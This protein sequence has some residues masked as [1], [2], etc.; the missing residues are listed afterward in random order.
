MGL[1]ILLINPNRY[2]SP[3]VIPIGLEYLTTSLKK[4]GYNV[5]ILDLCFTKLP[6]KILAE[7]LEKEKYDLIGITI[8]NIDSAIFFN[9]IFFLTEIKKLI[10]YI[11]KYNIPIILGGSGFSA[12]PYEILDYLQADYGIIGPGEVIFPK[13][14]EIWQ[15]KK[16]TQKIYNGWKAGIDKKLIHLRGNLIN[17]QYYLKD[18]G[19]IGFETHVGCSNQ[20]PYCIEANTKVYFKEIKAIIEELKYLIR[21]GY[22]HFHTCDTEFNTD[23][24]FSLDFCKA[25]IKE[26]LEFKWALYMKPNPYSE[27]LFKL[28]H[29][30]NAYLI[31]LSVDSYEQIQTLNNYNYNDLKK[32]IE[33]SKKYNIKLAID[34]LVGFPYETL[35]SIKNMINFFKTNRPSTVGISFYYRI[36]NHTSLAELIKKDTSLQKKLNNSYSENENFLKPIFFNQISLKTIEELILGDEDLFK[37]SGITPGVNYQ[38]T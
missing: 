34:L 21:Q 7:Q 20:C 37:I 3:P 33:Y 29:K 38:Q 32:I 5:D 18:E 17:Y 2:K 4:Y 9:N 31:T 6:E 23:L 27:E 15:S 12:M 22:N 14:L 16:I 8:R 24:N 13:F 11:K 25:I 26:N 30:S 1:K 19:I 10:Q 36:Y 35:K 28:L